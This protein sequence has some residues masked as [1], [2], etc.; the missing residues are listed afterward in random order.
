MPPRHCNV[1]DDDDDEEAEDDGE[2]CGRLLTQYLSLHNAFFYFS[3]MF[4]FLGRTNCLLFWNKE[5]GLLEDNQCSEAEKGVGIAQQSRLSERWRHLPERGKEGVHRCASQDE[6]KVDRRQ[7][8][9]LYSARTRDRPVRTGM[10]PT[11]QRPRDL[12]PAEVPT[13]MFPPSH[14]TLASSI[15]YASQ[16]A[17]KDYYSFYP[18]RQQMKLTP[19]RRKKLPHNL[20]TSSKQAYDEMFCRV[21]LTFI[22]HWEY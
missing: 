10:R 22:R 3:Y 5:T 14:I 7:K 17:H 8:K 20:A 12:T 9:V 1:G 4:F 18:N 13:V 21:S 19:Q 16:T 15:Q 6:R 2:F 11:P